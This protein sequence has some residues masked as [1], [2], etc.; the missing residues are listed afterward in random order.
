MATPVY[1]SNSADNPNNS[2]TSISTSLPGGRSNGNLLIAH[3]QVQASGKTI[4]VSGGAWVIGDRDS[5]GNQ[6]AAWA[7][8]LVDGTEVA[9]TFSWT[10]AAA[11]EII[12]LRFSGNAT[13]TP[14]GSIAE[15]ST[16]G[17]CEEK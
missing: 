5:T 9:P 1:G 17:Y 12:I 13:P 16:N 11:C 4:A 10:G 15:C 8:C 2:A 6:S 14:I 3:V 7:W